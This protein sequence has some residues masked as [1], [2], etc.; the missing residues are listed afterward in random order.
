[1]TTDLTNRLGGAVEK[2]MRIHASLR[3]AT[4]ALGE[5]S[6]AG[7]PRSMWALAILKEMLALTEGETKP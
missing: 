6:R 2:T 5:L 4:D 1:M 7:E 3:F